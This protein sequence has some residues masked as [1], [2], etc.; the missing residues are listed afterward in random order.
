MR[1]TVAVDLIFALF[2]A[3]FFVQFGTQLVFQYLTGGVLNI[4][5]AALMLI[6]G[7]VAVAIIITRPIFITLEG[8]YFLTIYSW[9]GFS[10]ANY[11]LSKDLAYA[12]WTKNG[13][14]LQLSFRNGKKHRFSRH[15]FP[16]LKKVF[17][18]FDED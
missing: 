11:D 2:A 10:R 18:G 7:I 8:D 6:I 15:S 5:L 13:G 14:M 3:L 16:G 9:F 4:Q 12:E 1:R 17:E